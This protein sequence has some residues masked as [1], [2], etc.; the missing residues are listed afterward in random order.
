M[1]L[2]IT[3]N[4]HNCRSLNNLHV[5]IVLLTKII[6]VPFLGNLLA[7]LADTSILSRVT[8]A[9]ANMS[10]DT[11]LVNNIVN[12]GA[13]PKLLGIFKDST[14][15]PLLQNTL[16][17]LRIMSRSYACTKVLAE[18]NGILSFVELLQKENGNEIKRCCLQTLH[19]LIRAANGVLA[20]HVQEHGGI[21]VVCQLSYS[22]DAGIAENCI[23]ILCT[24]TKY[25]LVRVSVGT[26]GGIEAFTNQIKDR[27]P[28]LFPSIE[29]ICRCCREAVNRNK[30]RSSGGLDVLLDILRCPEYTQAFDNILGAFACFS[31][32]DLALKRMLA[33]GLIPILVS[34]L[35]KLLFPENTIKDVAKKQDKDL[36]TTGDETA[37]TTTTHERNATQSSEYTLKPASATTL[38]PSTTS[39]LEKSVPS[40]LLPERNYPTSPPSCISPNLS[41]ELRVPYMSPTY[42]P[43]SARSSSPM[44]YSPSGS[45]VDDDIS[46]ESD[47]NPEQGTED[48]QHAASQDLTSPQ[49]DQP[50]AQASEDGTMS[51]NSSSKEWASRNN[52]LT[53]TNENVL[54]TLMEDLATTHSRGITMFKKLDETDR[55]HGIPLEN[56]ENSFLHYA[57][58]R[59]ARVHLLPGT[60]FN[61]HLHLFLP[62]EN[63][64]SADQPSP[65]KVQPHRT[66]RFPWMRRSRSNEL[67]NTSKR[68]D[69]SPKTPSNSSG[70]QGIES[71]IIFLLSRFG[72]MPDATDSEALMSPACIQTLLDYMCYS[73]N[74]DSRCERLFSRLAWDAKFFETLI[75]IMF[76]GAI[77]R[78]LVCG[79]RP[80][81]LLSDQSQSGIEFHNNVKESSVQTSDTSRVTTDTIASVEEP[82]DVMP[83]SCASSV[84]ENDSSKFIQGNATCDSSIDS[85]GT[86]I[87]HQLTSGKASTPDS[88]QTSSTK[89]CVSDVTENNEVGS[90]SSIPSPLTSKQLE[91]NLVADVA[92]GSTM[93]RPKNI[94]GNITKHTGKS[95][96]SV[97]TTQASSLFGEG[98]LEHLLLRGTQK[99]KEA[100]ALSLPYVCK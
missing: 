74:P 3:S 33:S 30:V 4:F 83:L 100:C 26:M 69:P 38:N 39:D 6:I 89:G 88:K 52:D 18:D 48:D 77:Y 14:D 56:E 7:S 44:V 27:G 61:E 32:D 93:V 80:G 28:L 16:R 58:G 91:Q 42:S 90:K 54:S 87:L 65:R 68:P 45:E 82:T 96:L 49:S 67:P 84:E 46:S 2:V 37:A 10:Q 11:T 79:L 85:C 43:P 57:S 55:Q 13:V 60:R 62:H 66:N 70:L 8:R 5:S 20:T 99:Q 36:W 94:S 41:P 63:L 76:P 35:Q 12:L 98:I 21:E 40:P 25:S 75:V 23:N 29:G 59:K 47:S 9:L 19:E 72:Q 92:T 71:K 53:A 50:T 15:V 81:Y 34:F 1:L 51:N 95:L 24:L 86:V 73:K 78:Q 17:A 22:D 31:Y 97:L 64:F